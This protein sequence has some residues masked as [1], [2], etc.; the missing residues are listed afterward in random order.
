MRNAVI[1]GTQN[2]VRIK[3]WG[4][5]NNGFVR[6]VK[7]EH[8]TMRNVQNPIVVDQNYC[9]GNV[10]C[11]N[12]HSGIK[13]SQVSYT[14]VKG[15]SATPVAVKFDCSATNP[16]NGMRLQDIKLTYQNKPAMSYCKNVKGSVSGLVVP[17]SCF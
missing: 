4:K 10:N 7:F 5:P 16:C 1:T 11:P 2:G 13:I 14:D 12:Q 8:V 9:P 17:Q 3:T 6:D 15:T